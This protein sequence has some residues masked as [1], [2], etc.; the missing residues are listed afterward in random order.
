MKTLAHLNDKLRLQQ[1]L[2]RLRPDA[3][4]RWGRMSAHQMICHLADAFRMVNG[5]KW[6]STDQTWY[7]RTLIKWFCL[8]GPLHWPHGY[9]TRPELDQRGAGTPPLEFATDVQTVAE[10][11]DRFAAL[12]EP[13]E[14]V[15]HPVFGP[16]S[17]AQWLRWSWLHVDHHLRQFGV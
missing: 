12:R 11:M 6:V 14:G 15:P 16:M 8:Y 2:G 4:R 7:N 3:R 9:P 5:E 13:L 10:L 1:R 17:E